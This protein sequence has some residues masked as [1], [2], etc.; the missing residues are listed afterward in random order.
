MTDCL[1]IGYN[2][3][4]F[5]EYLDMA[6]S[7]G[8]DSGAYRDL[9]LAYVDHQGRPYRSM[10]LLNHFNF[11]G[12]EQ[13]FHG[14]S[15]TDFLWPTI[16]YLGSYLERRGFSFDYVNQFQLEKDALREKLERGDVLTVAITTSLYVTP[17]P[18]IEIISFI[19]QCSERVKIVVG[20]PYV[21]NQVQMIDRKALQE[22]FS[23]IAADFYV[24]SQE[25]E[26]ALTQLLAALKSGAGCAGV[27]NIAYRGPAGAY[28]L[29]GE[30]VERNSLAENQVDYAR[31]GAGE[32]GEFVSL[33]T[34]KSCPFSCAFC[35]FPQRAGKYTY[36]GVDLVEQDLDR[37]ADLGSVT[38]LTFLDDTF[39]VPK[40]RFKELLRMMA[41]NRY[42]FKWNSF[43]RSDHGD[44]ETIELM[45][46]AGCEGVFLGVESGSDA[47]LKQMNKSSRRH[48][49]LKAIPLFRQAGISTYASFIVGFPGETEATVEESISLIEEAR[50]E[51][52]RAQLWYCDP[53]TPI[54]HRREELGVQ[55]SAFNWSHTTMD[56]QTACDLIDRI[57]LLVEGSIWLP[58]S[59]FEQWS[60]FY[61]QRKGF[62]KARVNQFLRCW[63]DA[64]REQ[65]LDPE[66]S[67]ISPD[68]LARLEA[69][70][71]LDG[72]DA[73]A[74]EPSSPRPAAAV[75]YRRAEEFW[76]G[77]L[78]HSAGA[79]LRQA[80][81]PEVAAGKGETASW[82]GRVG[83]DVVAELERQLGASV[84]VTTLAAFGSLLSRIAG[85]DGIWLLATVTGAG[86]PRIVPVRVPEH[87]G[88]SFR[89]FVGRM[90]AQAQLAAEHAP[91]ALPLLRGGPRRT[92]GG[93][94]APAFQ[95]A[96]LVAGGGG[97]PALDEVPELAGDVG[98]QARVMPRAGGWDLELHAAE[99]WCSAGALQDLGAYLGEVLAQG[100]RSPGVVMGEI[101]LGETGQGGPI[102]AGLEE[103]F[104]F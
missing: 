22:L 18:I 5:T 95:A 99:G 44:E 60:T 41:R 58:Q 63:N 49:Y 13:P 50:P 52:F 46:D 21:A 16:L 62:T 3:S 92:L 81:L 83:A 67:A 94:G 7:M 33:R 38:T 37:L 42:G 11:A 24:I 61:L 77:E 102:G 69:S 103:V 34:A 68:L 17:H 75:S 70:C 100:A 55:G 31:F 87:W 97:M 19:R 39:N 66:R 20:G 9:N 57:F 8:L 35:G 98:L 54:W 86:A 43:Y 29:T 91:F 88:L 82:K 2:D 80:L 76:R 53:M 15:N 27:E 89:D 104:N 48:N 64:V 90:E 45:R 51:Y 96:C 12:R 72:G 40:P 93:G 79:D 14:Y 32:V 25:G 65:L 101:A 59:G 74:A 30:S 6:R 10:D 47:M 56:Q 78:R 26:H 85:Q 4:N 73:A 36:L 23:F 84:E 71:R 28:V 1:I